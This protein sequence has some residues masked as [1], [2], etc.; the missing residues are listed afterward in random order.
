MLSSNA[1]NFF[2]PPAANRNY[3]CEIR[4]KQ[5]TF[6]PRK[7]NH[8]DFSLANQKTFFDKVVREGKTNT[9]G[10][11]TEKYE[12][13]DMYRNIGLLQADFYTTVFDETGRPVS[14]QTSIPIYTQPHYFGI[15]NDG[16]W[17][18]RL[19]QPVRFPI[20]ALDKEEKLLNGVP[21]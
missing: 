19:N 3:E 12:V 14:R 21:A 1:D 20:I 6:A 7:Y 10:N 13:Q 9:E 16:N 5:K 11:A 15:A 2:G 18:Y 17:Y 4:L 8:Y